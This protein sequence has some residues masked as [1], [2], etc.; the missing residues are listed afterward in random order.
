[1]SDIG[2]LFDSRVT[3]KTALKSLWKGYGQII[4]V[5]FENNPSR[6]V[7]YISPPKD[8]SDANQ[9][10]IESFRIEE[11]FYQTFSHQ[12]SARVPKYI[13]SNFTRSDSFLLALEDLDDSGFPGRYSLGKGFLRFL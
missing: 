1:M 13:S 4:R 12:T 9:Q 7:K 11:R 5:E 2:Q 6:I 8:D 10:K 3:S